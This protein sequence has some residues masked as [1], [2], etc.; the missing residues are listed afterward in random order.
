MIL[1]KDM[2]FYFRTL[3]Y[4]QMQYLISYSSPNSWGFIALN[5]IF[6]LQERDVNRIL[7]Y[8][9]NIKLKLNFFLMHKNMESFSNLG[10]YSL[11][12]ETLYAL[13][14]NNKLK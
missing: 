14:I 1:I 2:N 12:L 13:L 4:L 11:W 3:K 8:I 5:R 7:Q 10:R 6:Y 9:T